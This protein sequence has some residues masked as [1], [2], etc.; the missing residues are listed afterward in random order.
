V[1]DIMREGAALQEQIYLGLREGRSVRDAAVEL[2]CLLLDYSPVPAV[3]ELVE[4]A[5]GELTEDRVTELARQLIEGF[6][7][8][9][10]LAP[11]RWDVLVEALKVAVRDLRATGPERNAEVEL[12]QP[13]WAREQDLAFVSYDG[14]WQGNG[15]GSWAGTDRDVALELVA[16]ALQEQVMEFTRTVWPLCPTHHTGLH[17]ERDAQQRPVWHCRPCG[18]AVAAIGLVP[19]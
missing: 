8:G 11:E 6:E 7:P 17:A 15:V 10:D 1:D 18:S 19:T 4:R 13:D 12:V 9:F 3:H 14:V 2:A 16:D 5:P